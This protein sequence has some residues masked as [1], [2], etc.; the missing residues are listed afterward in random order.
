MTPEIQ[1]GAGDVEVFHDV[2]TEHVK[3]VVVE[4]RSIDEE[5]RTL[6]YAVSAD[7]YRIH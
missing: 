6:T 3:C 2:V 7:V 5:V 1:C 4:A